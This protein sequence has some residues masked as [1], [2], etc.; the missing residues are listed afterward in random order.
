MWERERM[1]RRVREREGEKARESE[2]D[3]SMVCNGSGERVVLYEL[4]ER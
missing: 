3:V 2:R 1:R 4:F